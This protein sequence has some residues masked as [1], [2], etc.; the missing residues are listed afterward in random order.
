MKLENKSKWKVYQTPTVGVKY[1]FPIN[2]GLKYYEIILGI[3]PYTFSNEVILFRYMLS[4]GVC[5][6]N[7]D[8]YSQQQSYKTTG[9]LIACIDLTF[10]LII[11]PLRFA[12]YCYEE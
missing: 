5:D 2:R 3:Y 9:I 12:R 11:P 4:D 7:L 6:I 8:A 10:C 1:A